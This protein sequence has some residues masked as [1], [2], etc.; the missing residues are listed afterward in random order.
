MFLNTVREPGKSGEG[1]FV[2]D[3][4]T[5][6]SDQRQTPVGGQ[7]SGYIDALRAAGA[8]QNTD[9]VLPQKEAASIIDKSA[10][11]QSNSMALTE[12]VRTSVMHH[13]KL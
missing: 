4:L 7:V 5:N 3:K 6:A 2:L 10:T 9:V 13:D 8:D 12:E 11:T 1:F